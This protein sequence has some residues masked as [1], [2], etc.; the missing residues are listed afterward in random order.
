MDFGKVY[1][2]QEIE[3]FKTKGWW[4]ITK[5]CPMCILAKMSTHNLS[6]CILNKTFGQ[7]NKQMCFI[8]LWKFE[9]FAKKFDSH[10]SYITLSIM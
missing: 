4:W 2:H 8:D 6:S 5:K 7:W 10:T 1:Y 9:N 3:Q